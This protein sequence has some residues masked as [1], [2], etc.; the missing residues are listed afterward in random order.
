MKLLFIINRPEFFLS[1]RLPIAIAARDIGYEVHVATPPGEICKQITRLGFIHHIIPLSRSGTKPWMEVNSIWAIWLLMRRVKPN[2]IHLVTIKA[3]LYGGL[4][5]RVTGVPAVV[6]AISGL[7]SVFVPHRG[8]TSW[9]RHGIELL[10]RLAL[11]HP[12]LKVIFQNPNDQAFLMG[13]TSLQDKQAVLIRGSGVALCDY[14]VIPEPTG[15]PVVTFA[16]RL[17]KHK[18]VME[19]VEAARIL[20]NRG[21]AFTFWLVGEPDHGNP[22]S[23]NEEEIETWREAGLIKPLGY[24]TDIANVFTNSNLVVLPSYYGE[25][26]PKVL[27][28]A[29][30]TGRA[31]ITTDQPGCR[32]AIES[33]VT[34]LLVPVKDAKALADAIEY[35]I[36]DDEMR[37]SMGKAGRKLAEREFGIEKVIKAHLQIYQEL[38][39]S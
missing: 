20:K 12:N 22:S 29:A 38:I 3:V 25:G 1:H 6:M 2:L 17:L 21:I 35:L 31:V 7:G 39:E 32:D 13:I 16:S 30:A 24:R 15:I 33:N 4:V 8:A 28:E 37:Q 34:G 26:L 5:A 9:V 14:P 18:G 19:F 10:Y 23:I 36:K 27:I 11:G